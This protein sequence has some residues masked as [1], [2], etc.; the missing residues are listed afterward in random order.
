MFLWTCFVLFLDVGSV[1]LLFLNEKKTRKRKYILIS[2]SIFSIN[3]QLRHLNND[4]Y[5]V[6]CSSDENIW[7]ADCLHVKDVSLILSLPLVQSFRRQRRQNRRNGHLH[8]KVRVSINQLLDLY[9]S[10]PSSVT[11]PVRTV[12]IYN[13]LEV[14]HVCVFDLW[15]RILVSVLPH[16][17]LCGRDSDAEV[18]ASRKFFEQAVDLKSEWSNKPAMKRRVIV[19]CRGSIIQKRKSLLKRL[20]ESRKWNPKQQTP[21]KD[22]L[23]YKVSDSIRETHGTVRYCFIVLTWIWANVVRLQYSCGDSGRQTGGSRQSIKHTHTKWRHDEF[24]HNW[25]KDKKIV[26]LDTLIYCHFYSTETTRPQ[27]YEM[28]NKHLSSVKTSSLSS[29]HL[30]PKLATYLFGKLP[31]LTRKEHKCAHKMCATVS[32]SQSQKNSELF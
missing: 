29:K 16:W 22:I 13:S 17:S 21:E 4:A 7:S 2:F 6:V 3:G 25:R 18:S 9:S 32:V 31:I 30:L 23:L 5:V 28:Y 20:N 11:K 24:K 19:S 12:Q 15:L 10:A 1:L 27:K 26:T 8:S 14:L